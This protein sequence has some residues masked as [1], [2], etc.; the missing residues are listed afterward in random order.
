MSQIS[1]DWIED[2][3]GLVAR[4]LVLGIVISM[5]RFFALTN[6]LEFVLLI[7]CLV[8]QSLRTQVLQTFKDPRIALVFIFWAWVLVACF[9][10][11]APPIEKFQDWWSWRKLILVPICFALFQKEVHKYWLVTVLF[12]TCSI[13]LI[14][15]WLGYFNL[16]TLDRDPTQL[17]ENYSTQ[18]ILFSAS[19]IIGFFLATKATTLTRIVV[20]VLNFGFLANILFLST[21]RA[22]YLFFIVSLW[23]LVFLGFKRNRI[24][25]NLILAILLSLFLTSS[26]T[27]GNRIK[28][29]FSEILNVNE[30]TEISSVGFRI[31][32]WQNSMALISNRLFLGSGS[33]SFTYDYGNLIDPTGNWIEKMAEDPRYNQNL[34][35]WRKRIIDD[36]HQQYLHVGAEYGLIG[37]LFFLTMLFSWGFYSIDHPNF[38]VYIATAFLIGTAANG[39]FNGHFS[40]FVEGRFLWIFLSALM[41]GTGFRFRKNLRS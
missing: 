9:W 38:F 27:A 21:G 6:L 24:L 26:E 14:L 36:P 19:C 30:A 20:L 1:S 3:S 17:L 23:A 8:N 39:F 7:M 29:G 32:A 41:A 5:T 13:Y 15:S 37:L 31:T 10:G 28:Q 18:G 40:A 22:G 12:A 25:V 16:I 35:D 4:A 2:R 11:Q 33:G 34:D